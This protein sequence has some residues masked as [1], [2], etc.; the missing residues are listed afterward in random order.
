MIL[1]RKFLSALMILFGFVLVALGTLIA[2]QF[3]QAQQAEESLRRETLQ[4]A[5]AERLEGLEQ[6]AV[7]L[8]TDASSSNQIQ[9]ALAAE[10][11]N[12]L[13]ALTQPTYYRQLNMGLP[14]ELYEYHI[15]PGVS[16]LRVDNPGQFGEDLTATRRMVAAA[17]AELRIFQG[18]EL[19]PSG[20][21]VRAVS[22]VYYLG[23]SVGTVE[24][25]L[26]IDAE[27]LSGLKEKYRVDWQINILR[28][29]ARQARY[30][31][32]A[33]SERW[34]ASRDLYYEVGTLPAPIYAPPAVYE[35][36][37][38]GSA[39]TN[40]VEAGDRTYTIL[41]MPLQD[42][43]GKV[44]GVVDI[45]EDSSDRIT[46]LLTRYL[47]VGGAAL[48]GLLFTGGGAALLIRRSF[49]P[50]GAL[51]SLVAELA[52]GNLARR[53]PEDQPDEL[54]QLAGS[55]NRIADRFVEVRDA[56]EARVGERTAELERR[57]QTIQIASDL[58]RE[59][60]SARD[61]D[62][63]LD[64][65]IERI[66]QRFGYYHGAIFLIDELGE[67]AHLRAAAGHGSQQLRQRNFRL[68]L[69]Q[70]GLVGYV[71][72]HGRHRVASDVS[73]DEAHLPE[74]LLSATRSEAAFPL[75]SGAQVIG[76]VD[77]Q[78]TELRAFTAD[79]V[80]LLQALAD[81]LAIAIENLR[82]QAELVENRRKTEMIV[83][84]QSRNAW[85]LSLA[86]ARE[87]QRAFEYDRLQVRPLADRLPPE[88]TAVLEQGQSVQTRLR[89]RRNGD[90]N[91][92]AGPEQE[93][94][95]LLVPVMLR[96]QVIG[97]IGLE[98]D[99]PEH[100]WSADEVLIV[101]TA[102]NQAALTL[103]NVRL[104]AETRRNAERQAF[105]GQVAARVRE[106]LDID[107]VLKTAIVEIGSALDVAE[108]EVRMGSGEA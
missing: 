29:A 1:T 97:V 91:G 43:E 34:A 55:I 100:R 94:A 102:A 21:N 17:N 78:S 38:Q 35:R 96:D 68:R 23:A 70:E 86:R 42:F 57:S 64:E 39:E 24:F 37:L 75:R 16:F 12:Q 92:S 25:G 40:L 77:L 83:Q 18:I 4:N 58:A 50:L 56:L 71:A 49:G 72:A 54:G 47:E 108:V 99:D 69:G 74:G 9:A 46:G 32:G 6:V 11:R 19:D 84:R 44:I 33:M 105:I 20:L 45:V 85:A 22:P 36:V 27:L 101:E 15:P 8:A 61:L 51:N 106:T 59:M 104:L 2:I 62:T 82:L 41:T 3:T 95:A 7:A 93:V 48:L 52:A 66:C 60:G 30:R 14:V 63:L 103:E 10:D 26:R 98:D 107:T 81:Q 13:L 90:G 79:D 87:E 65:T 5:F 67:Y 31:G 76:V 53:A 88:A 80:N 89:R 73:Q 28:S